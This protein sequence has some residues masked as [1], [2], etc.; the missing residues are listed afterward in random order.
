LHRV[1]DKGRTDGPRAGNVRKVT[2]SALNIAKIMALVA[3]EIDA[4]LKA[5]IDS[6]GNLVRDHGGSEDEVAAMR[7]QVRAWLQR[8]GETLKDTLYLLREN[9][10]S[11][12]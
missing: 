9:S 10:E 1:A 2:E 8:G 4:S 5:M 12:Y 6:A 3:A 7:A 11:V